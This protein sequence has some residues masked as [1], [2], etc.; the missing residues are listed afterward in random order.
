MIPEKTI[1]IS[2]RE[3]LEDRHY[4]IDDIGECF[5]SADLKRLDA[6]AR[7]G[8][9]ETLGKEW[10][11][12]TAKFRAHSLECAMYYLEEQEVIRLSEPPIHDEYGGS[13]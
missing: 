2:E 3:A 11:A 10:D 9:Y 1:T 4:D 12:L 6:L 13:L 7:C 8:D 5:S